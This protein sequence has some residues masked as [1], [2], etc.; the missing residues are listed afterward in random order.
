MNSKYSQIL[1]FL[2]E[3]GG[4]KYRMIKKCKS[5]KEEAYMREG[6]EQG[7]QAR[8]SFED[9]VSKIQSRINLEPGKITQ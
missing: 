6:A 9:I 3:Y 7:K 8:S 5:E 1:L 2:K 4:E